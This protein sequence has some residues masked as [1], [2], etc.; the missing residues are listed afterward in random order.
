[1]TDY[2]ISSASVVSFETCS[3]P[4]NLS[5]HKKGFDWDTFA[6]YQ[7]LKISSCCL[8]KWLLLIHLNNGLTVIQ[9]N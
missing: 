5:H 3:L 2:F 8:M 1:M 6:V 4:W 9:I 7:P